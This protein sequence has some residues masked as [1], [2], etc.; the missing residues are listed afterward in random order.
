MISG[1]VA[2][3]VG[4]FWTLRY[5]S[6]RGDNATGLE[7]TVVAAVLLGGVS[8]FGGKG[9][10]PGVFAGVVLLTAM[11]NALPAGQT[12]RPRRSP[13]SPACCSSSPSSFPTSSA[14]P[15]PPRDDAGRAAE[16]P[17]RRAPHRAA[18]T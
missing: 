8:I 16:P 14:R 7:L 3:L 4:V 17:S 9:T 2:G 6:A 10:L 11:Q 1:A 15:G 5:S 13:S 18:P 12:S